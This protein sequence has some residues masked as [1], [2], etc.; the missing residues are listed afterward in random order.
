MSR[1]MILVSAASLASGCVYNYTTIIVAPDGGSSGGGATTGGT[2]S[3]GPGST[4]ASSSGGSGAQGSG[5]GRPTAG[6]SSGSSSAGSSTGGSTTGTNTGT[7][8]GTGTGATSTGGQGGS[9]SGGRLFLPTFRCDAGAGWPTSCTSYTVSQSGSLNGVGA[10]IDWVGVAAVDGGGFLVA[11]WSGTN[12][13][14]ILVFSV[15]AAGG[16]S[17]STGNNAYQPVIPTEL[18]GADG[19]LA[20]VGAGGNY[21]AGIGGVGCQGIG[22]Y[23]TDPLTGAGAPVSMPAAYCNAG[24]L[25]AGA[26]L[27]EFDQDCPTGEYC[28]QDFNVQSACAPACS[29]SADCPAAAPCGTQTD[30]DGSTNR[31][32]CYPPNGC[33]NLWL[34]MPATANTSGDVGFLWFNP[35][36]GL[37]L[38]GTGPSGGGCPAAA[39]VFQGQFSP[40]NGALTTG[41]AIAPSPSDG[42]D[43]FLVAES[44]ASG[45][46]NATEEYLTLFGAPSGTLIGSGVYGSG[47]PAVPGVTTVGNR[48]V[49]IG[50]DALDGGFLFQL[51]DGGL[52][53]SVQLMSSCAAEN[54]NPI[55]MVSCG[56]D[57]AVAAWFDF[58]GG[59]DQTYQPMYAF[60]SPEG[61][62]TVPMPLPQSYTNAQNA[63]WPIDLAAQ[64]SGAVAI[65]YGENDD[66]SS[67]LQ[68]VLCSP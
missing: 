6:G 7:S 20:V 26:G 37:P 21:D 16:V 47:N 50:T 30:I 4:S 58:P 67:K 5:T 31:N 19:T 13:D 33:G 45:N 46:T 14:S 57:C 25:C 10:P 44:L 9:S 22:P 42:G 54:N 40:T 15:S 64:P 63:H 34:Q 56:S 51:V 39:T 61:C 53:Q 66:S 43:P 48:T 27:C 29:T 41:V 12:P 65:V 3:S 68:V 38:L 8:T 52:A 23:C 55:H 2:G 11:G 1:L 28:I 17:A 62:G 59:C 35:F 60:F 32:V 49:V 18:V 36:D 24:N